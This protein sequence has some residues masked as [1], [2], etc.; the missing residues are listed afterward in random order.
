MSDPADQ[1]IEETLGI[2]APPERGVAKTL[3]T[4]SYRLPLRV[5]K[6]GVPL[7]EGDG[8]GEKP[9]I[10][11]R[12]APGVK[13]ND[14]HPK[15]HLGVDVAGPK[16]ADVYPIGPGRVIEVQDYPKS[17]HSLKIQHFPDD[18]L[19]S[20]YAHLDRVE[21]SVGQEVDANTVIGKNGNTG[22]AFDTAPHVHF[23]CKVNGVD[24]DPMGVIGKPYGSYKK[25]SSPI[26][27]LE[28]MGSIYLELASDGSVE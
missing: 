25:A 7:D 12:W 26:E 14:K 1:L 2:S 10:I 8:T 28:K 22:N 16:G 27:R 18:Q 13:L 23:Q 20:F 9:W 19:I 6:T 3:P 11:G 17:G 15:G 24:V 21:V 5:G 4:G